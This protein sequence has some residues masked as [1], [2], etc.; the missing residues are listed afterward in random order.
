MVTALGEHLAR[1]QP[2]IPTVESTQRRKNGE[3]D[4]ADAIAM[5][6]PLMPDQTGRV[7]ASRRDDLPLRTEVHRARPTLRGFLA[8]H[9]PG[10]QTEIHRPQPLGLRRSRNSRLPTRDAATVGRHRSSDQQT[11]C[12]STRASRYEGFRRGSRLRSWSR[13]PSTS[14]THVGRCGCTMNTLARPSGESPNEPRD[15]RSSI[16]GKRGSDVATEPTRPGSDEPAAAIHVATDDAETRTARH[17]RGVPLTVQSRS[18][19][20]RSRSRHAAHHE[21]RAQARQSANADAPQRVI[22]SAHSVQRSNRSCRRRR[23]RDRNPNPRFIAVPNHDVDGN[24][25]PGWSEPQLGWWRA[26][27]SARVLPSET[28]ATDRTNVR[29]PDAL[30]R[31]CHR[32][33]ARCRQRRCSQTVG[34]LRWTA[35]GASR[36]RPVWHVGPETVLPPLRRAPAYA[37]THRTRTYDSTRQRMDRSPSTSASDRA[38]WTPS[39]SPEPVPRVLAARTASPA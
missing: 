17:R 6:P 25:R 27:T 31:C 3:S 2:S 20:G 23:R 12:P 15:H 33:A 34:L 21:R 9:D 18:N 11:P 7:R 5:L 26:D 8:L 1:R 35:S 22:E 24:R 37:R 10:L 16:P 19:R 28:D 32:V 4:G 14:A 39:V 36:Q 30:V 29:M 38:P 13:S